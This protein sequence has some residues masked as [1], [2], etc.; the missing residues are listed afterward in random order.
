MPLISDANVAASRALHT[1]PSHKDAGT[2]WLVGVGES[3]D[4]LAEG[5]LIA[6][7]SREWKYF[8]DMA[9][10]GALDDHALTERDGF[11][12]VTRF[13]FSLS[14]AEHQTQQPTHAGRTSEAR[15]DA[16]RVAGL[17]RRLVRLT[18]CFSS[19]PSNWFVSGCGRHCCC[20]GTGQRWADQNQGHPCGNA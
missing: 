8:V 14:L 20:E 18:C 10:L 3:I 17:L 1:A 11:Y 6:G 16:N 12:V 15:R 7:D 19:Q 2:S 9:A 4:F 5:R 13:H